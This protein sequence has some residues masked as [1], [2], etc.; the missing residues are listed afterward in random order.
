MQLSAHVLRTPAVNQPTDT[1]LP[2]SPLFLSCSIRHSHAQ[3]SILLACAVLAAIC[4]SFSELFGL[5]RW[6]STTPL[7][8]VFPRAKDECLCCWMS[9]FAVRQVSISCLSGAVRGQTR[10]LFLSPSYSLAVLHSYKY[11]L[12]SCLGEQTYTQDT[13]Q[14]APRHNLQFCQI[15]SDEMGDCGI[16]DS[17]ESPQIFNMTGHGCHDS[18]STNHDRQFTTYTVDERPLGTSK[19]LR[20]ICVGAGVSGI[21]LVRTLRL[22]LKDYEAVVYDKNEGVGGTWF[23]NRYPGC[24]C[25]IPSHCYQYSW[26]PNKGWSNFFS[27]A[28]EIE[29]YLCKVCKE[30]NIMQSI[31]LSHQVLAARWDEVQ[32]RWNVRIRNLRTGEDF[33][34][35]ADFLVN[36]CGIL[37]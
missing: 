35:S 17:P 19:H 5:G 13:Y 32:G 24:K 33:D 11:P 26:R 6:L 20:I 30:E 36:G 27:T 15:H 28:E 16:D 18:P 21:N 14:R 37:K 29:A 22:N 2:P 7:F 34:D 12:G 9:H 8:L 23:E 31:K 4:S 1:R 3:E 25:D 10:R